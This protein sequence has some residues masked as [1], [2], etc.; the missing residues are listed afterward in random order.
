MSFPS[1]P[2]I[3]TI[4]AGIGG[5]IRVPQI[6]IPN[7]PQIPTIPPLSGLSGLSG[8]KALG[9][10]VPGLVGG[11]NLCGINIKQIDIFAITEVI[12]AALLG[13]LAGTTIAGV[14]G[15]AL[16]AKLEKFRQLSIQLTSFQADLQG[17]N[18]KDPVAV[19]AF[20]D[21]WKDKVPGGAGAYVKSISDALNKGLAFD[22]CSLVPNI[23]IDPTTGLTKVLAKMAPTPGEA[24]EP[25][26]PLKVTVVESVKDVSLGNS[27]VA[28]NTNTDFL[29]QVKAPW[30]KQV[31]NPIQKRVK[32]A[33]TNVI[34]TQSKMTSVNEKVKKY[35]KSADDLATDGILTFDEIMNL[36][37]YQ[38]AVEESA[39][40]NGAVPEF[41]AWFRYYCDVVAGVV[42]AA[43]YRIKK[44][45][46][47]IKTGTSDK[48]AWLQSYI[49]LTE[50]I[51]NSKKA[52]VV[53]WV[54]YQDDKVRTA[55]NNIQ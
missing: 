47:I 26:V 55:E 31:Q 4:P 27:K 39:V 44:D 3:P 54:S 9:G 13:R 32:E 16:L 35:G 6:N 25:S 51:I 14:S 2:S 23:N 46:L 11:G 19:A 10:A 24:P 5:I 29:I 43:S 21:R 18:M 7:I 53:Q 1:I 17:L 8:L 50:S 49:D 45:A 12:K 38:A 42:P 52:L 20:L 40:L 34:K 36:T 41:R 37:D 33:A 15:V 48:F 30:E 28:M 22:Y